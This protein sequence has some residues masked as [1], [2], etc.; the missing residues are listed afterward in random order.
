MA[1]AGLAQGKIALYTLTAAD[2][3]ADKVARAGDIVP[4]V[5]VSVLDADTGSSNL[6]GWMDGPNHGYKIGAQMW[7][8]ARLYSATPE[9]GKWHWP[10]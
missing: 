6:Y 7:L 3:P 9:S 1:V 4:V 8:A 10:A 2:L 5:V